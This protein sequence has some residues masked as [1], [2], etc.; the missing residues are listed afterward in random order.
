MSCKEPLSLTELKA[1]IDVGSLADATV[2]AIL[3]R[4]QG[5]IESIVLG[6]SFG[7]AVRVYHDGTGA[8]T[9]ATITVTALAVVLHTETILG[10]DADVTLPLATYTQ[11]GDLVNAIDDLTG[12]TAELIEVVPYN[13]P[14]SLLATRSAT[15]VLLLANRVPLCLSA[16]KECVDG[17]NEHSV[18]T[19]M[20]IRS[21]VTV[22]EDGVLL[23]PQ[24]NYYIKKRW[25]E[26]VYA[27]GSASCCCYRMGYWS[28]ATPCNVCITYV[29]T[30]WGMNPAALRNALVALT[31]LE[32]ADAINGSYQGESMGDYS[33]TKAS[34]AEAWSFWSGPLLIWAISNLL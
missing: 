15:D 27:S 34:M 2:Q 16:W 6:H 3:D 28:C 33:Y 11:M 10:P 19:Q 7:R 20:P 25:L 23:T 21:V 14:T 9:V 22:Y 24:T 12:W 1:E 32:I 31:Q 4:V 17:K 26:K 5:K 18:F 29:P 30:W 8:K 13:T